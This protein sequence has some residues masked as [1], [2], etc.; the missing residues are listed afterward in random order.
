M[1][2]PFS[3]GRG[4]LGIC[5]MWAPRSGSQPPHAE[6]NIL[7]RGE[8][9]P[10]LNKNKIK[11]QHAYTKMMAS[12]GTEQT[13]HS[14]S[15]LVVP[16]RDALS[17]DEGQSCSAHVLC[18]VEFCGDT[19]LCVSAAQLHFSASLCHS[20]TWHPL[21]KLMVPGRG[22]IAPQHIDRGTLFSTLICEPNGLPA[23]MTIS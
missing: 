2:P 19:S 4:H 14:M 17:N 23:L 16:A 9:S 3:W 1:Q 8:R 18:R 5:G 10:S 22:E 11:D 15:E 20:G 12:H 21:Q 13:N 6:R 7:C